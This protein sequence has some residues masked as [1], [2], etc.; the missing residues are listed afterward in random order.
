[1]KLRAHA[2]LRMAS[3][4]CCAPTNL[5]PRT[6][7]MGAPRTCRASEGESAALTCSG[8]GGDHKGGTPP[9]TTTTIDTDGEPMSPPEAAPLETSA[10]GGSNEGTPPPT[11]KEAA[12][13]GSGSS[14]PVADTKAATQSATST[15]ETQ[16]KMAFNAVED[17]LSR[18]VRVRVYWCSRRDPRRFVGGGETVEDVSRRRCRRL[19]RRNLPSNPKQYTL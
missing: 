8:A 6:L 5:V 9:P 15:P 19:T 16:L 14:N 18:G 3:Q 7:A 1:M 12:A 2:A 13:D 4:L 10:G 11:I 17:D